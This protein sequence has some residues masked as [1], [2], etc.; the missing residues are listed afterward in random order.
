MVKL[1]LML[2]FSRMISELDVFVF[3]D[4]N[5]FCANVNGD[6]T[7]VTLLYLQ[8]LDNRHLEM[9]LLIDLALPRSKWINSEKDLVLQ[10][11]K[12]MIKTEMSV[13]L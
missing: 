10:Y 12:E 9:K 11:G 1:L 8:S 7:D 3:D 13:T 5:V 6:F 2:T 4:F